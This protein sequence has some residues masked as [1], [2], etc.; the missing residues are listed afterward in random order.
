MFLLTSYLAADVDTRCSLSLTLYSILCLQKRKTKLLSFCH[1][2]AQRHVLFSL[3]EWI[4]EAPVYCKI[5][6][7]SRNIDGSVEL[8]EIYECLTPF[9]LLTKIL[10]GSSCVDKS[11]A[12][13]NRPLE[14]PVFFTLKFK[15]HPSRTE[16]F[17]PTDIDSV[18][19]LMRLYIDILVKHYGASWCNT[20]LLLLISSISEH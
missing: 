4:S 15:H 16:L 2:G 13:Y 18:F 1:P 9:K 17:T 12:M 14:Q 8:S 10:S 7:S 3:L 6:K 19:L 20:S 11:Q 5:P